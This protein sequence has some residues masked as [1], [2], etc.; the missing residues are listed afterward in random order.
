[1]QALLDAIANN[2]RD[3]IAVCWFF[4]SW[5]IYTRYV[6]YAARRRKSL[7][8][9]MVVA[10]RQWM[11]QLLARDNRIT[12][13]SIIANLERNVSFLA[14]SALLIVAALLTTLAGTETAVNILASIPLTTPA[15]RELWEVKV[16]LLAV[17]FI[18][19][20]FQFT[21]SMRQY[22][23]LSILVGAA[24]NAVKG[25]APDEALRD[26]FVDHAAQV[27]TLAAFAFNQGLR[28]YYFALAVL[29]W[30]V[31]AP[32]FMLATSLVVWVLYRREFHS[33]AVRAL[34]GVA[35]ARG[36]AGP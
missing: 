29:A 7:T 23:F 11:A 35:H 32:V 26:G 36:A 2:A 15:S 27:A 10:R 31:S 4:A 1:M 5:T 3:A 9:A 28:A 16:M 21:W 34:R 18:Y 17:V 14:S 30:L 20:F 8:S 33:P 19:A 6:Q 22:S 13:A 24:P 12:D 25:S